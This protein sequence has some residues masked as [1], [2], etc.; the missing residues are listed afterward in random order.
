MGQPQELEYSMRPY[1]GASDL[2]RK[3]LE[4]TADLDELAKQEV[5]LASKPDAELERT[6]ERRRREL[7]KRFSE[8]AKLCKEAERRAA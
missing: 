2:A 5:Q 3:I 7:R 8:L 6:I 4:A 1:R